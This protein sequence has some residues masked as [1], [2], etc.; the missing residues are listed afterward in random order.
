MRQFNPGDRVKKPHSTSVG[1]V[2]VVESV[3]ADYGN[4]Q[5]VGYRYR[6]L[7]DNG[8]E[9]FIYPE[10]VIV[11]ERASRPVM[12]SNPYAVSPDGVDV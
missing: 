3:L 4:T 11:V 2:R 10:E 5:E 1:T 8:N 9:G 12:N 7:W 6:V